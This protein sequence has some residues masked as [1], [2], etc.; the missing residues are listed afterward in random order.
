M[1]AFE[2]VNCVFRRLQDRVNRFVKLVAL[3]DN[4]LVDPVGQ[5]TLLFELAHGSNGDHTSDGLLCLRRCVKETGLEL[6][7]QPRSLE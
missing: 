7:E 5:P 4:W 2:V 3:G 6:E 1:L